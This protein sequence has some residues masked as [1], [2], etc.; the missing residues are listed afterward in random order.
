MLSSISSKSFP[1]FTPTYCKPNCSKRRTD[2]TRSAFFVS[3]KISCIPPTV[4]EIDI[5]LSFKTIKIFVF[6]IFKEKFKDVLIPEFVKYYTFVMT[7]ILSK[8]QLYVRLKSG[9]IPED[10]GVLIGDPH[11]VI[12][13]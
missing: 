12:F 13:K 2:S 11:W 10:L 8:T 4:G 1:F 9:R 6:N 3:A 5:P 7:E